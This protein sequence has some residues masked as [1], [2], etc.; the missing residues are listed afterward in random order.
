[1]SWK[2]SLLILASILTR[3]CFS[4]TRGVTR[5]NL[6]DTTFYKYSYDGEG[7]FSNY[8][9]TLQDSLSPGEWILY[10]SNTKEDL[11]NSEVLVVGSFKDSLRNGE[12]QYHNGHSILTL[13]YKNGLLHGTLLERIN[14]EVVNQGSYIQGRANGAFISYLDGKL[15][16]V[17]LYTNDT[18]TCWLQYSDGI[19][20]SS[21]YGSGENRD[22]LYKIYSKEGG[23]ILDA[24][25]SKG[26]LKRYRRYYAD[27]TIKEL[28]E[29][30]FR[31]PEYLLGMDIIEPLYFKP[32]ELLQGCWYTYDEHGELKE[33]VCK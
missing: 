28:V 21:G 2:Y 23:V 16:S 30:I 1:M 29:G 7:F 32:S 14:N 13:N 33:V 9:Y 22:G 11:E 17:S 10:D 12:F 19:I 25:F 20:S 3:F 18:L 31:K 8:K 26:T 24:Y 6:L 4:Q 27:G 15:L 5:L